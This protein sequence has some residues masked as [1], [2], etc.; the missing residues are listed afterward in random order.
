MSHQY[1]NERDR[2]AHGYDAGLIV[3]G[4]VSEDDGHLIL[5][6]ED[7]I[8]FDPVRVLQDLKGKQIRMTIVTFDTIQKMEDMLRR[9]N[10]ES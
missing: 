7:G 9:S 4:T 10:Q 5:L 8:A 2:Y 6:D 1:D 3:D